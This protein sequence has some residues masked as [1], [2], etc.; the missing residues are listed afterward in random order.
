[1]FKPNA[2][3]EFFI[4]EAQSK[5]GISLTLHYLYAYSAVKIGCGSE[6]LKKYFGISLTLHYLCNFR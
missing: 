3:K 6:M 4:A 2:K 1:M 5:F